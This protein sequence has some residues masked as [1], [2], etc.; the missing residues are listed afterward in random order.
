MLFSFMILFCLIFPFTTVKSSN[1][2]PSNIIIE[3]GQ[4]Y[5]LGES[6][7]V[8]AVF[9]LN[10]SFKNGVLTGLRLGKALGIFV[11][12]DLI[13]QV[14]TVNVVKTGIQVTMLDIGQGD[15]FQ[16]KVNNRTILLDTGE[17]SNYSFLNAQ[18]RNLGVDKIDTLIIS[19]MDTDHMGSTELVVADYKVDRLMVPSTPGNSNEYYKLFNHIEDKDIEVI[20]VHEDETYEL[21]SG[22]RLDILGVD[23]GEGTND[24]SIVMKISYYDN[25][26]L[27]IGD[28]SASVLNG[29][30]DDG[31]DII[32]DVLKVSHHGS[33]SSNPLLFLKKT[34]AG[35]ALISVGRDNDYGH[36]TDNVV[37]RL[38]TLGM[39]IFRTDEDGTVSIRG[40]GKV[41]EITCE[42]IVDWDAEKRLMRQEGRIIGNINSKVYHIDSCISLP[43]EKNRIYFESEEDAEEA[44]YRPC[45]ICIR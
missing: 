44:G 15:S 2:I 4:Q 30:M 26:F 34:G 45:G 20:T 9:G 11:G 13:P 31:K 10:A 32:A 36:P 8:G 40:D 28:A 24:S 43:A 38:E 18:L 14:F 41:L 5:E 1:N 35:I 16:I 3:V 6:T 29:I 7:S 25:S 12:N 17:K 21:G 19:H 27:F 22:C 37:R 39:S 23:R 42:H 33:D